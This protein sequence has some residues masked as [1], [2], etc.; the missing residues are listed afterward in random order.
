M[1][2]I[3]TREA[4]IKKVSLELGGNAATYIDNSADLGISSKRC[5]WSIGNSGQFVFTS[6]EFF[7]AA[8]YF[9]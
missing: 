8:G 3:I 7:V 5:V 1:D 9:G 6:G 2:H 4:G